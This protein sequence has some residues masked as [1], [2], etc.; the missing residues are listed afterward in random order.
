METR[1]RWGTIAEALGGTE[2]QRG[3]KLGIIAG[4]IELL[5][6]FGGDALLQGNSNTINFDTGQIV[7]PLLHV[8]LPGFLGLIVAA[9]LAYYAGLSAPEAKS[10]DVGRA[11]LL[12]GGITMLC[13]WV[14]QMIFAV[15]NAAS[16]PLG[17]QISG[18][19]KTSVIDGIAFFIVGSALGWAGSRS[20]ARRARFILAPPASSIL[21]G[22][23]LGLPN[24]SNASADPP[25]KAEKSAPVNQTIQG[26]GSAAVTGDMYTADSEEAN[27]PEAGGNTEEQKGNF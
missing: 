21:A 2:T 18:F 11:G 12:S 14:G 3:V 6:L 19:L 13:F 20:A 24:S 27:S 25:S 16:S 7:L 10:G 17:L 4:S 15:V 1:K 5:F 8:F 23:S 9:V 22:S 26:E